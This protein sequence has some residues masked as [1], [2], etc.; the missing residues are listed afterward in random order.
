MIHHKIG[1]VG[2]GNM[3]TAILEGVLRDQIVLPSRIW[4]YDKIPAK[5][6][7]FARR[8]GVHKA[9]SLEALFR[10]T[11]MIILAMKPQD[12]VACATEGRR[13]LKPGHILIS[14]L[15]GTGTAGIC[16][17][18]GRKVPVVRAMPNLGAKVGESMTV[19]CG[20]DRKLLSRARTL[21]LGC[22]KVLCLPEA[23]FDLVTALSGS[24]P[25][26]FF[27]LMEL[28][29]DFGVRHGLSREVAAVLAV[30]T[31]AGALA[32]AKFSDVPPSVLRERVTPKKGTTE[33]ALRVLKQKG[34]D[35]IFSQGVRAAMDRSRE[36]RQRK[37][38]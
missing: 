33:A 36:L 18:F 8:T 2:V 16:K 17:V 15:A 35:V 32:L 28:L 23:R 29:E 3:G 1:L 20:T 13:F 34:F 26:Y 11:D 22:G 10:N 7:S 5:A 6:A 21:F 37:I 27:Y 14:I 19:I 30:Q 12:L 9:G 24:G 25:A 31:G 4:V 38:H